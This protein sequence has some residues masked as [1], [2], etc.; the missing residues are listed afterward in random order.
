MPEKLWRLAETHSRRGR[1]VDQEAFLEEVFMLSPV[2][3]GGFNLVG[4]MGKHHARQQGLCLHL[5]ARSM[6]ESE[7]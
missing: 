4:R 3:Q 5:V 6:T 2:G 1:V 7:G